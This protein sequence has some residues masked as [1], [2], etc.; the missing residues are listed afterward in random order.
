MSENPVSEIH[1]PGECGRESVG[2]IANSGRDGSE[3]PDENPEDD[4]W[5]E[6]DAGR[7]FDSI[8][9]L[10]KFG[11]DNPSEEGSSNGLREYDPIHRITPRD[12]RSIEGGYDDTS[13]HRSSYDREVVFSLLILVGKRIRELI[14]SDDLP[15]EKPCCNK[16]SDVSCQIVEDFDMPVI[17]S[18]G[19]GSEW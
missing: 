15:I 17:E 8:Q 18:V 4:S 10:E 6:E 13:Q 9:I 12:H 7:C 16:S 3:S 5:E 2:E 11:C 14:W 1:A 19:H